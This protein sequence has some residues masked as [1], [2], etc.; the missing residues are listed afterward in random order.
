M[1]ARQRN[2]IA[3][4]KEEKAFVDSIGTGIANLE[5]KFL[6]HVSAAFRKS[7]SKHLVV[8][9]LSLHP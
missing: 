3:K 5:D 9:G 2:N 4:L 8:G 7:F 6:L 1:K